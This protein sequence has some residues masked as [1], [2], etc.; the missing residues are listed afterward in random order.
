MLSC[1]CHMIQDFVSFLSKNSQHKRME[2]I[3]F[4]SSECIFLNVF[5]RYSCKWCHWT[6][7]NRATHKRDSAAA[8][9]L[10]CADNTR[11]HACGS[12]YHFLS[13]S[14][15]GKETEDRR[16]QYFIL[17]SGKLLRNIEEMVSTQLW[18][19]NC[20]SAERKHD[21]QSCFI[22]LVKK[23]IKV[24]RYN[25]WRWR[26]QYFSFWFTK[27]VIAC[28]VNFKALKMQKNLYPFLK[29]EKVCIRWLR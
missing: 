16:K 8:P 12:S 23:W 19:R 18:K 3:N 6:L 27:Q 25:F 24:C 9:F 14:A 28:T 4:F 2:N 13:K 15:G 26:T 21:A 20:C 29:Q 5:F 22:I 11:F 7:L 1:K 17:L 10:L